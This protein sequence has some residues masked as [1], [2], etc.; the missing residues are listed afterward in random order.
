MTDTP[1]TFI[2]DLDGTLLDTLEDISAAVNRV[3]SRNGFPVHTTDA[4]RTFVGEGAYELIARAVPPRARDDETVSRLLTE[5]KND[6]GRDIAIETHAYPGIEDLLSS[7][8]EQGCRMAILSNK[9]HR[10]TVA[11]VQFFFGQTMFDIVLG[12]RDGVPR[13]PDPTVALEIARSFDV[14]PSEI[15]YLGDTAIDMQTA[16]AAEMFPVGVL[17]GFR[18]EG[19]LTAAGARL[20][21]D[22]P[23]AMLAWL[24]LD[25][26]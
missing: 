6:Y 9:P 8:R 18:S 12:Q 4:I 13:K 17:W 24:G 20:L 23:G 11:L 5:F 26:S 25:K 7:L 21:I 2:F 1:R 14:P 3:L 22:H 10:S 15:I 19:E 16:I